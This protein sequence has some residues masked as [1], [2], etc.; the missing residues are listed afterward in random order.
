MVSE[1]NSFL[2]YS[3][4]LLGYIFKYFVGFCLF[5][6]GTMCGIM[7][8][9][10]VICMNELTLTSSLTMEEINENFQNVDFFTGIMDGLQEALSYKKG[11][12]IDGNM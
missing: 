5:V 7:A 8:N 4:A 12:N 6:C 9:K 2:L 3:L 10:G 11:V 1:D